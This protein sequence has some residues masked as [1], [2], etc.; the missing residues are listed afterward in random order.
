MGP[1]LRRIPSTETCY[2][3]ADTAL[4]AFVL[5]DTIIFRVCGPQH[6]PHR[7]TDLGLGKGVS[8]VRTHGNG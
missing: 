3:H 6:S 8:T 4:T 7:F 1:P 2:T 5:G